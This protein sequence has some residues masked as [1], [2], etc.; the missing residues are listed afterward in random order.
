MAEFYLISNIPPWRI[1]TELAYESILHA[2]VLRPIQKS[3]YEVP[4][5][6]F[7]WCGWFSK[8][9]LE[10]DTHI[11]LHIERKQKK[12]KQTIELTTASCIVIGVPP[13]NFARATAM[14]LA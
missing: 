3:L 14:T 5:F 9:V 6:R 7:K 1:Q 13:V 11:I 8:I 10:F 12:E 2:V 4:I